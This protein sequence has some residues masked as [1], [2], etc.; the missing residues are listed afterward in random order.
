MDRKKELKE[1]YKQMKPKMGVFVV[2][3]KISNRYYLEATPNLKGKINSTAFQLEIGSHRNKTLQDDWKKYGA[4]NFEIKILDEL[5]YD[6]DESKTD[7]SEEL[8]IMRMI[9]DE[10]LSKQNIEPYR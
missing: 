9:W 6:E 10:K 8:D 2:Q 4:E 1:K 5:K 7:Y 3:S